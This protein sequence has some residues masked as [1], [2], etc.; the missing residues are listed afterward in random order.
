MKGFIRKPFLKRAV[1]PAGVAAVGLTFAAW[2]LAPPA[3]AKA[4]NH[5]HMYIKNLAE[6]TAFVSGSNVIVISDEVGTGDT[7][8]FKAQDLGDVNAT[9]ISGSVTFSIPTDSGTPTCA[10]KLAFKY[11][12]NRTT[13]HCDNKQFSIPMNYGCTIQKQGSCFDASSCECN[14]TFQR[15]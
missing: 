3:W 13:G 5:L 2:T 6:V 8:V 9:T 7:E 14:F 1:V 11:T 15:S 4:P 12:Y 10:A